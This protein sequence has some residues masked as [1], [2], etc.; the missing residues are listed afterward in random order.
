MTIANEKT[1]KVLTGGEI[2]NEGPGTDYLV[3]D[4]HRFDC[5]QL[6]DLASIQPI[7]NKKQVQDDI[8]RDGYSIKVT[9]AYATDED[10]NQ[11]LVKFSFCYEDGGHSQPVVTKV[12][13][14][15]WPAELEEEK[16]ERNYKKAS[17]RGQ[18]VE[19]FTGLLDDFY[20]FA[21]LR[22]KLALSQWE[23]VHG[24]TSLDWYDLENIAKDK[25]D[26]KEDE[27]K[28][29]L[30]SIRPGDLIGAVETYEELFNSFFDDGGSLDNDYKIKRLFTEMEEKH[31]L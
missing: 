15:A 26:D 30:S 5:D 21:T 24:Y 10:G 11:A 28:D 22:L 31:Q 12:G 18:K 17:E 6:A 25:L 1:E 4:G 19:L 7:Q 16:Y 8:K 13:T 23:N 9:K 3:I 14:T 29:K 27:I 2:V 20:S